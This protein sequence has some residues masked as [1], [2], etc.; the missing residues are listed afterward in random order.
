MNTEV[1]K[2][3]STTLLVI[4]YGNALRG[5]DR[6]GM[7][8]AETIETWNLP[9]VKT[10]AA[11]QLF[12]E[13]AEALSQ[14]ESAIF[15]DALTPSP[16]GNNPTELQIRDLTAELQESIPVTGLGSHSFDPLT[17]LRLAEMLYGR[18]PS[19]AWLL[20]VPAVEMEFSEELSDVAQA[21]MEQALE[22]VR[23]HYNEQ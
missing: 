22:W 5:D 15:V 21:G 14:T 11:H 3:V 6:V 7:A 20:M 1:L 8:I 10:V 13:L 18:A 2:K 16:D 17:L 4:G 19:H 23:S 12:P 9:G